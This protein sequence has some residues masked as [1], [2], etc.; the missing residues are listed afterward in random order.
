MSDNKDDVENRGPPPAYTA[1]AY[2]AHQYNYP[3]QAQYTVVTAPPYGQRFPVVTQPPQDYFCASVIVTIMCFWPTGIIAIMRASEARE[4]AAR[5]DMIT[6][7]QRS[8]S[9]R[10]M[11]RLTILI[12]SIFLII[13]I[14]IIGLAIGLSS[15]NYNDYYDR[16]DD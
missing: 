4:A 7:S 10:S 8:S 1:P 9:A 16:Y 5:G 12:G 11:V 14:L 2:N 6:A 3:P 13:A 15:R